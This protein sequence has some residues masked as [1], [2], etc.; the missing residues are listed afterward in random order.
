VGRL[1]FRRPSLEGLRRLA[2]ALILAVVLGSLPARA[3]SPAFLTQSWRDHEGIPESSVLALAQSP[4]G[5]LW[6]GSPDGLLRFNGLTFDRAEKFSDLDRLAG[7]ISFLQTD[8]AGRLWAGGEGRLSLYEKGIWRPIIGTN[9]ALC[10]VA[11]S[12]SGQMLLGG[13]QGQLYTLQDDTVKSLAPPGGLRSSRVFCIT[14]ARD[15][16]IWLANRGF[17]GRAATRGWMRFTPPRTASDPVLA[18]PAKK[19]GLWVFT[20]GELRLYQADGTFKTFPAPELDDPREMLEDRSGT[21]WIATRSAGLIHFQPGGNASVIN[22]NN[23]LYHNAIR[24]LLEDREGNLWAGGSLNGLTRFTPRQFFTIGRAEGLP[25]NTVQTVAETSSGQILVGTHG[26]GIARISNGSAEPAPPVDPTAAGQYIWSLIQDRTGRLWIGTFNDGLFVEENGVRRRF[27]L[28]A[29]LGSSITRLMEDA[30]GRIWAGG[31]HGLGLIESNAVTVCFTNSLITGATITALAENPRTGAIWIGTRTLGAFRMESRNV[32]HIAPIPGLAGKRITSLAVDDD[33][34]LWIG[35]FEQGLASFH[36]GELTAV[37]PAQGLPVETVG[38]ILDDGLGWF[39]LGTTHGIIRVA[40]TELHRLLHQPSSPAVFNLF[41]VSDGLGSDYCAEGFQPNA[42]RDRSGH[43]WFGTDRG[44]V[45]VDPSRLSLNTNPPPVVIEQVLYTDRTGTNRVSLTPHGAPLVIPAGNTELEFDFNAL[46]FTA[47]EKVAFKYRLEGVDNEWIDCGTRR[48][49]HF[50]ELPRGHYVLHL[51]AANNDGVWNEV[52]ARQAFIIRPFLWQTFWFRLLVLTLLAAT[53]GFAVWRITR[54]QFQQRIDQL[55]RQRRLEQ[56]RVQLATVMENTSDLVLFADSQGGVLHIN[57]AGRKLIGLGDAGPMSGLRL[58]QLQPAWA[59]DILAQQG[60]PAARLHGTWESET[61]LLHRDGHEIL[62]SL[63]LIV[64]KDADDRDSFISAIARDV[65]ERKKAE[66]E[67][68]RREKYFR[69]LTEHASDSITVVNAQAI[70]T[71]Q[72]SSGERIL[73]Y[74]AQSLVGRNLFDLVLPHDLPQA[75]AALEQALG[76]FDVPVTLVAQLQHRDGTWRTVETVG[77]C[78]LTETGEKQVILNTRDVTN[79]LKLEEQLRQ[80][81]KME[82]VGQLAGGV[83]HD[84]NNI[85][86]SLLMQTELLGMTDHLAPE[87]R[88]GLQQIGA[89]TRR[90]A[91]LTR[92]LLLFSRRQVMQS[93]ALDLNEVVMNLARMLQRVIREDVHL[94]LHLHPTPLMT[95]ADASMVD[96]VLMNLTVNARDAMTNGGELRIETSEAG[97]D[98]NAARLNPDAAPGRYVCLSV[99]DTG[100]GIPPGILPRIFEPFFT[101]KEPG[102]GTGLGLATVFGIVKQHHGWISLDNRPGQGVTFRVFLPA[103]TAPA[104]AAAG[105]NPKP[106]GGTETILLVEDEVGVRKSTRLI[107]ERHGYHV[108]DAADGA[109]ALKLWQE[110]RSR[111]ALL[112][113][114]LVMPGNLGGKDLGRRLENEQPGLKVIFASGYSADIAGRDFQLQS[115][116]AFIQKPFGTNTL[117]ETIRRR[118]DS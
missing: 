115:H 111:I 46:S 75:R 96:Q 40:R 17:I 118:L 99:S 56:E 36:D 67:L 90:A 33:G 72:S 97:V 65:T 38:P 11:N 98:A 102:R 1:L 95:V 78:I 86:S 66:V 89:D 3:G 14:D 109:E 73:G 110:H 42:L 92:Q 28:P 49:L 87:I 107:L 59:A 93:R 15:G 37:G 4:D 13:A 88:E 22:V 53:G 19:G 32:T 74:P 116:E 6:V 108:L 64:H 18:A 48:A 61:A 55:Q 24:C 62:V 44:V 25:D 2:G 10:S 27:P 76:Q 101:T 70:I 8:A 7:E 113:T 41:T 58:A 30:S 39:W 94:Q 71:Y 103:S 85:L 91:D 47:P 106:P 9:L 12:I 31:S 43:L 34:C 21:I 20:P 23:G 52:G 51:A 26:G 104:A 54:Q 79:N 112:F 50:H 114:D 100:G 82:A 63:V 84:F 45:T 81:Q 35:I 83:A 69:S 29:A 5:Y 57:R 16:Q 117:L 80:A 77:S 60:I 68:Q 105:T